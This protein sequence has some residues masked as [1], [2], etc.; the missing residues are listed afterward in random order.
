MILREVTRR[1]LRT[2]I[3]SLGIA[4]AVA[5]LI[6]GRFGLDSL[7]H[8]LEGTL[9]REQRQDLAVS[10]VRPAPPRALGEVA[11]LPG[12][13]AAEAIRAVPVRIRNGHR[14]REAVLT[15][16]A[17]GATLR[18]LVE[19]G[20]HEVP[21]PDGGI[22]LSAK[23]AEVLGLRI[24]DR[25]EI[26]LREGERPTV[27]PTV[28]GTV[29]ESV[30]LQIYADEPTLAELS[31][32]EGAV[33]SVLVSVD[34]HGRAAAEERLR[35]APRVLEVSDLRADIDRLRTMNASMMNIWTT[36]S[37]LLAIAVIFGVVYNNARIALAMRSRDLA[38]LRVLGYTR[39]EISSIL[40]GGQ[41]IEVAIAIP[42]GLVLGR[43]WGKLFMQSVDQ[44][45]FRWKVVVAPTTYLMAA[46]VALLA[47]TAS[48]LW[49]RRHL[50]RLDLIGVLKTRE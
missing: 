38:S 30:G 45:M 40:I 10:F 12:V 48:A 39:R 35:R 4:G 28:L 44:E 49:V 9:R 32:D 36:V 42:I 27:A 34:E 17:P 11:H 46:A 43:L 26:E 7:D 3:S 23:L 16:L 33:S 6:L 41:A 14:M 5:L 47:A 50:D 19:R 29:N 2:L 1:P 25:P 15:G 13:T 21:V 24:G 18:R 37:I 8:Y 20:G 31:G 22:I